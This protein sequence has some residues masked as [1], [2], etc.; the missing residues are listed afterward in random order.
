LQ[1]IGNVP[2]HAFPSVVKNNSDARQPSNTNKWPPALIVDFFY[3][4]AALAAWSP[5]PFKAFIKKLN[6]DDYYD[7]S[8]TISEELD[9]EEGTSSRQTMAKERVTRYEARG[10]K[11]NEGGDGGGFGEA[12]DLVM[13]LWMRHSRSHQLEQDIAHLPEVN[14]SLQERVEAWLGT[15]D[16]TTMTEK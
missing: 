10:K 4:C 8:G 11:R 2:E 12:M 3:G 14:H 6:F 13:S 15:Q 1:F 16:L 9:K 5:R 7:M